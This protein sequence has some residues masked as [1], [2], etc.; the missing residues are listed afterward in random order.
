MVINKL[1][2]ISVI[3]HG[4]IELI[5]DLFNDIAKFLCANQL[6]VILTL[7]VPE[8]LPFL[9][10]DYVFL[11]RI[12][13]NQNS[14]GFSVNHNRAFSY[15]TGDFFCV[16]NP[17]I[18]FKSDPFP[19]LLSNLN[20]QSIGLVAPLMFSRDDKIENSARK[21][22]T[23]FKIACKALG[24]SKFLEYDVLDQDIEPDWVGGM[25]MLFPRKIFIKL[26]QTLKIIL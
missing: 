22:P 6:E 8:K 5:V 19:I 18:R 12:I 2:T 21:F 4:Q 11:K 7:N 1:V 10:S 16:L 26:A 24:G 9:E 15:S 23:P 13:R 25:F 17:D 14:Q 20:D 3:S